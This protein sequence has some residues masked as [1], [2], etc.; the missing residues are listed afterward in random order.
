MWLLVCLESHCQSVSSSNL[1]A[2]RFTRLRTSRI[3]SHPLID[4][5]RMSTGFYCRKWATQLDSSSFNTHCV[6]LRQA[7]RWLRHNEQL[8]MLLYLRSFF[9]NH[10]DE[11]NLAQLT[12]VIDWLHSLQLD[13]CIHSFLHVGYTNLSQI[14]HF[15]AFDLKEI[16]GHN[17]TV[18]EQTRLVDSL[19]RI[20]SQL[21]LISS[22]PS[23]GYLVWSSEQWFSI[24]FKHRTS[25]I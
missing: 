23:E 1:H 2:S 8:T 18:E 4:N 14:C 20:R 19:T 16:I 12:S 21:I 17:L 11:P 3:I 5:G 6:L 25:W 7:C 13:R 22:L 15:N 24:E 9:V 10:P